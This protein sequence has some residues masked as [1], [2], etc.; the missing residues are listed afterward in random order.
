MLLLLR[1]EK[2]AILRWREFFWKIKKWSRIFG[3]ACNQPNANAGYAVYSGGMC[4]HRHMGMSVNAALHDGSVASRLKLV[5]KTGATSGYS[6]MWLP[7]A[8]RN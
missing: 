1:L 6:Q 4:P 8:Y 5:Y 7:E 2:F 3:E